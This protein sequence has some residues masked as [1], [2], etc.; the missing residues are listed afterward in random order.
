M[1]ANN[2]NGKSLLNTSTDDAI[3]ARVYRPNLFHVLTPTNVTHLVR[4]W[5]REDTP[6]FDYA[7][8]D[9]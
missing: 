5:F 1:A 8:M 3:L 6:S 2:Q 7:G 9:I 4:E